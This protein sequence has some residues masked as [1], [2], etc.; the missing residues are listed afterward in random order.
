MPSEMLSR[1]ALLKTAPANKPAEIKRPAF[2]GRFIIV[3]SRY[4]A[5]VAR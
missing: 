3:R 4:P 2:A 5:A 1:M